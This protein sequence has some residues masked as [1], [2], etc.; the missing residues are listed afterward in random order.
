VPDVL[1]VRH[2]AGGGAGA[3]TRLGTESLVYL[4]DTSIYSDGD[5]SFSWAASVTEPVIPGSLG[6]VR[7]GGKV[8][9]LIGTAFLNSLVVWVDSSRVTERQTQAD[10]TLGAVQASALFPAGSPAF[11]YAVVGTQRGLLQGSINGSG[12]P[13]RPVQVFD[14]GVGV[15]SVSMNVEAGSDA[16]RG[17]GMA[18]VAE[19][20]GGGLGVVSPVPMADDT[21]AGTVWRFRNLPASVASAP[22]KQVACTGAS[23][24]VFTTD[25]AN[26]GNIF[27]YTND[28]GPEISMDASVAVVEGDSMDA[29]VVLDEGTRV[30]LTFAAEDPDGDPVLLTPPPV[31]VSTPR[32]AMSSSPGL[33]GAPVVVDVEA[34]AVCKSQGVGDF[35]VTA[36]D[37]LAGHD[38]HK[39][40][41]VYVKHTRPP[42]LP[43]VTFPDG[44][45][46]P[47]SGVVSELRAGGPPLTL[48]V[49]GGDTTSE[50]CAIQ[51]TWEPLFSG[52]GGPSLEQDG[53][54]VV[55]TPPSHFCVAGGGDFD[56]QLRVTDEGAQSSS[57][58]FKV[59]VAP[60]LIPFTKGELL[61]DF[62]G[63]QPPLDELWVD[64]S[65]TLDCPTLR[66]LHADLWLERLDGGERMQSATVPIPGTWVAS[67]KEGC[68]RPLLLK[69]LMEDSERMRSTVFEREVSTPR[70]E[71]GLEALS[72]TALVARC[73]GKASVS[74]TPIF[75]REA[76]QMPDVTWKQ[77]DGPPLERDSLSGRTVSLVTQDTDLDS[78]VGRSV[79][80]RVTAS[81][82]PENETSRLYTL[83]VTA[84]PFVEVRRRTEVPAASETGLVGV[85]VNLLNTTACGVT[86]VSYVER[87][88][89]L[90]YVEG[91]AKLDGQPVNATWEEGALTVPGL[92]LAG[93]G[94]R[95]LTYVARPHLVGARLRRGEA[96]LRDVLISL[97][98][99]GPQAP[100]SGCGCSGSGPGPVLFALG[101]LVAAVRRRRR[102]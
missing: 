6:V 27:I 5:S 100:D 91:S 51:K 95:T 80:M 62:D 53:G 81:V 18:I 67:L 83:P 11:P 70:V 79:V 59:H 49:V 68:G 36:S 20:D 29:S 12:N 82:G 87:L 37:G 42:E 89:G 94:T 45:E 55:I 2:S 26:G 102:R 57:K 31:A 86:D 46:V 23:Y 58:V 65:S 69:G 76:C 92:T 7:V 3:V 61:L 85:S 60:E 24:C 99:P 25:Q 15:F 28:A 77:E 63:G 17:F 30:T 50:G 16:G 39:R 78:L 90:T 40:V 54:T 72:E 9:S 84:E 13:L 4:S 1:R 33:P 98:N 35:W 96:R 88:E 64:V 38:A 52:T 8:Y 34:R 74:L 44:G 71:A 41:Q 43:K 47:S 10:S 97:D 22:L 101:A 19:Q 14:A 66:G 48:R 32:W 21:R 56:F 93:E 75:P 73:G